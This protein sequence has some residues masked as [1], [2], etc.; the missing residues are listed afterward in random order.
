MQRT[1]LLA[2]RQMFYVTAQFVDWGCASPSFF[3]PITGHV[4][5]NPATNFKKTN[6]RGTRPKCKKTQKNTTALKKQETHH[7][8]FQMLAE[9][10]I[11]IL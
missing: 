2:P 11:G 5:A 3:C 7:L 10:S 1:R 6:E 8:R 4:V 9:L